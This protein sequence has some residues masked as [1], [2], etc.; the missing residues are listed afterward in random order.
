MSNTEMNRKIVQEGLERKKT[1]RRQ[2]M[3]DAAHDAAERQLRATCNQRAQ[4][5][6][7]AIEAAEAEER[8]QEELRQQRAADRVQEARD[9]ART[10]R[11]TGRMF[12]SL[13]YGAL[14]AL[15]F[16]HGYIGA[17]V[18]ITAIGLATAYCIATFIK[19]VARLNRARR[20][21]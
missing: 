21:A 4:E 2:R 11:L 1:A 17:G 19:Y 13:L 16:I 18:A 6:R 9:V 14:A 10:L 8:R 7:A 3:T 5:R 20:V 12:G 15:G